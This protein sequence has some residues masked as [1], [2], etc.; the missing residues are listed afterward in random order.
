MPLGKKNTPTP[1]PG[2]P[3]NAPPPVDEPTEP[4]PP[5]PPKPDQ[6]GAALR[7]ATGTPVGPDGGE[8]IDPEERDRAQQSAHLTTSTGARL[9]ETDHSL[10]AGR[11]GPVLLQD[12]HLREKI[13]HFD[14]ER[15][16][17]RVVHARGAAAHGVFEGY[18]TAESVTK[19]G[20][21]AK[22]KFTPVRS[23]EHTSEL[24]SRGHLV[25]RLLLE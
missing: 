21:L 9:R 4:T 13:T 15:I 16:P 2:R 1:P 25:C 6:Q 23:E 11:R 8:Q 24:Q 12:H 10:K 3:G 18:G 22:G 19:A 20:F 14:H 7:T 5:L 17:E